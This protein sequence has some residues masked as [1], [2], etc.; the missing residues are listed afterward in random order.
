MHYNRFSSLEAEI[1]FN[2]GHPEGTKSQ[3]S[4]KLFL[5]NTIREKISA[6]KEN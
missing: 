5:L 1:S 6:E 2:C 4:S 3:I